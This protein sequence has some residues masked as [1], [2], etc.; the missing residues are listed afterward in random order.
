M[1]AIGWAVGSKKLNMVVV[2][3]YLVQSFMSDNGFRLVDSRKM[4]T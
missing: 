1:L 3:F 2:E 4:N